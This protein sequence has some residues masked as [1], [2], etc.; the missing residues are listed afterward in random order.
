MSGL[1]QTGAL[2]GSRFEVFRPDAGVYAALDLGTNNCRLLLAESQVDGLKVVDGYSQIVRLGE[3]LAKTGRLSEPAIERALGALRVCAQKM[4]AKP[5]RRQRCVATQACRVAENGSAFLARAKAETGLEFCII[6]PE[7]EARL[8]VLGCSP[9]IDPEADLALVIDVGGGSTELS[10]VDASPLQHGRP[11][12]ILAWTSLPFGVVTLAE[13]HTSD[14]DSPLWYDRIVSDVEQALRAFRGADRLRDLFQEGRCH[15]VGTSGAVTSLAGVLLGLTRYQRTRVDGVWLSVEQTRATV[16]QL[17]R[18]GRTYRAEN[19]CIG[20]DR[21]D[22]VIPGGAILEAIFRV[23]PAK[24]V[25]VA[26]R[27]LREGVLF[28]LMQESRARQ[29]GS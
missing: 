18:L 22:L 10:W 16:E 3:G 29:D 7:E 21:A 11:S 26:D 12:T 13:A 17:R 25:R 27:G 15:Y 6:S 9:L 2:E 20:P 14:V 28:T 23:W 5:I 8:S 24:R 1:Q 4:A 19:P